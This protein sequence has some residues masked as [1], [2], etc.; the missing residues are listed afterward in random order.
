MY[1]VVMFQKLVS[2]VAMA[3]CAEENTD[4]IRIFNTSDTHTLA[5]KRSAQN[6][7][8]GIRGTRS[9]P[10]KGICARQHSQLSVT[11]RT[12]RLRTTTR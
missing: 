7:Q 8:S 5:L 11:H 2:K 4:G 10:F 1:E 12:L 9:F 3:G 6:M